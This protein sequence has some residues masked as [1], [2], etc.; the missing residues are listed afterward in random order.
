MDELHLYALILAASA[1]YGGYQ[2]G[3]GEDKDT[4][5]MYSMIASMV[6]AVPMGLGFVSY[7]IAYLWNGG[8]RGFDIGDFKLALGFLILGMVVWLG[9]VVLGFYLR[10]KQRP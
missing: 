7:L 5:V 8:R 3:L 10:R 4:G 9:G 1:G 2:M 6:F